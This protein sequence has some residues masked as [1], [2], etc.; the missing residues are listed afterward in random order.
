MSDSLSKKVGIVTFHRAHNY[1]AVLQAYALQ[2]KIN[3]LGYKAAFIDEEHDNLKNGYSLYPRI[4]SIKTPKKLLSYIKKWLFLLSDYKRKKSRYDNFNLFIEKKLNL[5]KKNKEHTLN[6]LVLGSDQIWNTD[7]TNGIYDLYYGKIPNI[8]FER[9]ISYAASMGMSDIKN[10]ED[11]KNFFD[12]I[13]SINCIGVREIKLKNYIENEFNIHPILN[14]DP[15]L[16]LK[17]EEWDTLISDERD[18]R[19]GEPYLLIYEVHTHPHTESCAKVIS[20]KYGLNIIRLAPKAGVGVRHDAITDA[21][22]VEFLSFF[23]NADFVITTSFHG[24]VFS[25]INEKQFITMRFRNDIDIRSADL[26]SQ[27][28]ITSRLSDNGSGFDSFIDYKDVNKNLRILRDNSIDFLNKSLSE[29][30]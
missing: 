7:Y 21:T 16:L 23:K 26:L 6:C 3:S 12:N 9:K 14:L 22:P 5:L 2:E 17:K 8:H 30:R 28:R 4:R 27:L 24:T 15:T 11:K 18:L 1:G 10:N 25:I 20:E 13:K 19:T 29:E